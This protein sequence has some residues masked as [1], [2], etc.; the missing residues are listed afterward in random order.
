M[1]SIQFDRD[2]EWWAPGAV[3]ERLFESALADGQ[4]APAMA[5]WREVADANGGLSFPELEPD[6]ADELRAGLRAAATAELA[7]LGHAAPNS[8]DATYRASLEKLLAATER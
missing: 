8:E 1:L 5:E 6:V 3:V 2:H 4:L 7:R